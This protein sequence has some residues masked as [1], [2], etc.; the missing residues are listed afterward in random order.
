MVGPG[1]PSQYEKGDE[2]KWT[3]KVRTNKSIGKDS[4]GR[5]VRV[6][7]VPASRPCLDHGV[8][9]GTRSN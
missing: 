7:L 6:C 1:T 4:V 5:I 9:C 8:F 3:D 2:Q